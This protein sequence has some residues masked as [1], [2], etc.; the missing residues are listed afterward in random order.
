MSSD[1]VVENEWAQRVLGAARIEDGQLTLPDDQLAELGRQ[2]HES[3]DPSVPAAALVALATRLK[4]IPGARPV[5]N[6]VVALA[7]IAL[8][9]EPLNRVLNIAL[10]GGG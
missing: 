1:A 2:I 10:Y 7:A 3:P 9:D 4:E 5:T 6:Q 8:G